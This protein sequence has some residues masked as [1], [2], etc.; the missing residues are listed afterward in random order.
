MIAFDCT[1]CGKCC[2]S[3]GEFIKIERQLT[4]R[5]YYCR[6][7]IKNELFLAH[8]EGD[9]ADSQHPSSKEGEPV[10][11]CPFMRENQNGKGIAC[12]IYTS[13]PRICRDF[14]CYRMVIVNRAGLECGRIMGRNDLKTT[15]E[16]LERIWKEH[17]VPL[18]PSHSDTRW[19]N[20]VIDALAAHGYLGERVE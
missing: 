4:S 2:A 14:R 3:F 10:K 20:A 9:Y 15:D 16:T 8:L 13:R 1:R 11:G 12:A 18:L 7:G 17:I 5:D 6:Y 19:E